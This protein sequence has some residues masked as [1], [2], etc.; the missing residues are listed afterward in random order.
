MTSI[1]F[2]KIGMTTMFDEK[3]N[4][5]PVTVLK[6]DKTLC[7]DHKI[8]TKHGYSAAI[9]STGEKKNPNRRFKSFTVLMKLA[10]GKKP[11]RALFSQKYNLIDS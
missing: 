11:I 8:E 1:L 9:L 3:S 4:S 10:S 2:K 5:I 7:V 6:L